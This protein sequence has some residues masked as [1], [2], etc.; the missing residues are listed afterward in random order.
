ME[1]FYKIAGLTVKMD[2][3]GRTEKQAAPYFDPPSGQ[4]GYCDLL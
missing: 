3:F 1:Q 2:T 4:S